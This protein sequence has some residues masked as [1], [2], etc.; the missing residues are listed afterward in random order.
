MR[1]T[2]SVPD[3]IVDRVSERAT[4]MEMTRSAIRRGEI[5]RVDLVAPLGSRPARRRPVWWCSLR[6]ALDL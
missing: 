4:A 2:I 6:R 1:T 3:E 5:H